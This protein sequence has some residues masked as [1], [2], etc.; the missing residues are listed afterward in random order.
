MRKLSIIIIVLFVAQYAHAAN[1]VIVPSPTLGTNNSCL[2]GT[3]F[4]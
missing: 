4:S 2:I 3:I 1:L